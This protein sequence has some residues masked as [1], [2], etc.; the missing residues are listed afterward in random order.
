[1][2][3]VTSSFLKSS[4]FKIFPSTCVQ[5]RSRCFNLNSSGLKSVFEKYCFHDGLVWTVNLTTEIKLRFQISP[6]CFG[7]GLKELIEQSDSA[8]MDAIFVLSI[9]AL[10]VCFVRKS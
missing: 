7:R 8:L 5:T 9:L 1:M 10:R 2:I 4:V 3:F 6:A